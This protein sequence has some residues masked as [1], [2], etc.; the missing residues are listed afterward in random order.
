MSDSE[1]KIISCQGAIANAGA[2]GIDRDPVRSFSELAGEGMLRRRWLENADEPN[3]PI[4]Q[5]TLT[6]EDLLAASSEVEDVNGDDQMKQ[7]LDE[8]EDHAS[9]VPDDLR[10]LIQNAPPG[11]SHYIMINS[12]I[13]GSSFTWQGLIGPGVMLIDL[14]EREENSAAPYAS[15]VS[16]ALYRHYHPMQL[17]GY[18]YV[19]SV[20]NG[21]TISFVRD[22]LYGANGDDHWPSGWPSG[23][24]LREWNHGTPQFDA[25]MGSRIG[26]TVAYILL[27]AFPRGTRRIGKITTWPSAISVDLRFDIEASMP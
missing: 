26:K 2:F 14:F 27:S 15:D 9:A 24:C 4:E 8:M 12:N 11:T 1:L 22:C 16:Q 6:Y 10:E 23:S 25:L 18:I 3:C 7:E 5:S 20:I 21:Q 17:L 13:R 19:T